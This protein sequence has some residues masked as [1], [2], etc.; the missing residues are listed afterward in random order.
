MR[1]RKVLEEVRTITLASSANTMMLL[2]MRQR[3]VTRVRGISFSSRTS[4]SMKGESNGGLTGCMRL[5]TLMSTKDKDM[6]HLI[7]PLL[8]E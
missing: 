2:D 7:Q 8:M 5:H 3:L 1:H 6:I 4:H